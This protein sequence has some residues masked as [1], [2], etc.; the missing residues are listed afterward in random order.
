MFN[1]IIAYI[2]PTANSSALSHTPRDRQK[3]LTHVLVVVILLVKCKI[4]HLLNQGTGVFSAY[5][6]N[7]VYFGALIGR[8]ANRIHK[9]KFQVDG[10]EY[11][12]ACNND[13]NLL[14]GGNIGW[15]KVCELLTCTLY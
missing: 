13:C 8:V 12:L 11:S 3:S 9:G 2:K 10:V 7:A 5:E 4:K 14:H 6:K 1:K 15:D